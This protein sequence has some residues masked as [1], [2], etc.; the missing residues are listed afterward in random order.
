MGAPS[1]RAMAR[2][3][4]AVAPLCAPDAR[5]KLAAS[6]A[7]EGR[8][9]GSL[10]S[11]ERTTCSTSGASSGTSSRSGGTSRLICIIAIAIRSDSGAAKGSSPESIW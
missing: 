8:W 5:A 11:A 3:S 1:G 7:A 10:C 9:S 6:T 2:S 4:D